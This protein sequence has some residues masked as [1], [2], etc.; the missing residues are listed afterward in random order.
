MEREFGI[1]LQNYIR[2][3]N[4]NGFLTAIRNKDFKGLQ[5]DAKCYII[6]G[7]TIPKDW[8]RVRTTLVNMKLL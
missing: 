3:N 6:H 4:P 8:Q 7:L 1:L 5:T 2:S